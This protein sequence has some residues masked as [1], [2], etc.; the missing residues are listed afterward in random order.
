MRILH[1]SDWH[2][3]HSL[4]V[5]DRQAEHRAFLDWLLEVLGSR[6]VDAMIVAGD[7][8]DTS[9]P[10]ADAQAMYYSFLRRLRDH[11]PDLDVL[12][13]GGN[14]D[15]ASRLDAPRPV[16]E[17]M[18]IQVVGGMCRDGR[19]LD[20]A[21]LVLPLRRRD[22]SVGAWVAAIPFLRTAD[23]NGGTWSPV[24]E[25]T[26]ES[27]GRDSLVE[28]VRQVYADVLALARQRREP[29][30][31]LVATGHCYMAN[32]DLS[33]LSE[34]RILGGN[35]HAL[36]VDLF[37]AD[38]SYVALGHLHK[39]QRVGGRDEV[40]YCG[41]PIP[42]SM[43]ERHY[44]HQVCLVELDGEGPAAVEVVEIPRSVDMLHVPAKGEAASLDEVL[45]ELG[46]LA[47][48]ACNNGGARSGAFLEVSLLL[49]EPDPLARSRVEEAVQ[50]RDVRLVATHVVLTGHGRALG[51][52]ASDVTLRDLGPEKVFR[53]RY[54]REH[55]GEPPAELLAAFHELLE[56][57]HAEAGRKLA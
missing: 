52:V 44:R 1:T 39:A 19:S 55:K 36:P 11:V 23:L 15:S 31:A 53:A 21:D 47:P 50:D 17:S 49:K 51:D 30:Q 42:L 9:N 12:V 46:R 27:E 57:V 41:S 48:R 13:I 5:H 10:S 38:L 32:T 37:P 6:R 8:F 29:G 33:D 4:N 45:A 3:G 22:G 43:T 24:V 28:G 35:Q 16:L 40:R 14:H 25:G 18:R 20:P 54:A 34:R 56:G 2:L 7:V 26:G